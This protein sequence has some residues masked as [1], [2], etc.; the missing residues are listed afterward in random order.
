MTKTAV[1][2]VFDVG[3]SN[4]KFFLYNRQY[5]VVHEESIQLPETLDDDGFASENIAALSSWVINNIMRAAGMTGFDLKAVN[6][7]A[8]GAS[9][10]HLDA[11]SQ[12]ITPFYN[13]LKP[14]PES[15]FEEFYNIIGDKR[16]FMQQTAAPVLG[17]LNS[18]L[19]LFWLKKRKPGIFARIH[20]S[21][22]LP[23]FLSFLLT[24]KKYSE[25]TSLGCHTGLW[26]FEEQDYHSWV[27][28]E[29]VQGIMAPLAGSDHSE[30]VAIPGLKLQAGVGL[31]DSSAA[32]IPYTKSF[33]EP[34]VLISTGTWNISLNPY[35]NSLLT[36]ADLEN[37]CLCYLNEKGQ[38]VKAS[39]LFAGYMHEQTVAVIAAHFNLQPGFYKSIPWHHHSFLESEKFR[40][41]KRGY[42]V[43]NHTANYN[44]LHDQS[45][46]SFSSA[47]E[48]YYFFMQRLVRLQQGSL[49]QVLQDAPIKKIFVDGGFS[50]NA[51]FMPMLSAAFPRLELFA[52]SLPQASALGSA[53]AVHTQWN[54]EPL[55]AQLVQ[56]K[57]VDSI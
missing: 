19:Q 37:N 54:Q 48:A 47:T 30:P 40:T 11:A 53:L 22:H 27:K 1:V 38:A 15:L 4:K 57:R 41:D 45:L 14:F 49:E 3:K 29:G 42:P 32:L 44:L 21:L 2:A 24:G 36:K 31:H 33:Q 17:F 9:L 12:V 18:G 46:D 23:Q 39:R 5:Q 35:N 10:V 51:V 8:Y 25:C 50:K 56:L 13:Y 6:F 43:A 26:N 34:F 55:P 28:Q 52:A 20:C 16:T 7:S